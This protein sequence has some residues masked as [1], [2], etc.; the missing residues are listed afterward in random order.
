MVTVTIP[1]KMANKGDLVLIPRKELE[2]LIER[3]RK[4]LS[5]KDLLSWS[6]D[7]RRLYKAKKLSVLRA[8]RAL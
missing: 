1:K 3:A 4:N 6:K 5:E 8:P 7:A 2:A